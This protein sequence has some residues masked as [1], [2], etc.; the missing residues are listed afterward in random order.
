METEMYFLHC[1]R[2]MQCV[3]SLNFEDSVTQK[4]LKMTS[5]KP[6]YMLRF[7]HVIGYVPYWCIYKPSDCSSSQHFGI[8]KYVTTEHFKVPKTNFQPCSTIK[9]TDVINRKSEQD[10]MTSPAMLVATKYFKPKHD[11]FQPIIGLDD[12]QIQ[13]SSL[14]PYWYLIVF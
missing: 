7:V 11:V 10:L 5:E 2:T 1:E 9:K 12:N 14:S 8:C 6:Q 3:Y 13:F 4:S